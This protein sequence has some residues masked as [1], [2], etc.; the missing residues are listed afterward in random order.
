[1][2]WPSDI[3]IQQLKDL[4]LCTKADLQ[5]CEP[6][7]SS[8]CNDLPDFDSVWLDALTQQRLITPWQASKL[9]SGDGS[10]LRLDDVLLES[11]LGRNTFLGRDTEH[12]VV[13]RRLQITDQSP[14]P[15]RLNLLLDRMTEAAEIS[16]VPAAICLP[17]IV[18]DPG[19]S[20]IFVV[21]EFVSGWSADELLIRGGRFPPRA[22]AEIGR[23]ILQGLAWLES[24][25]QVH[26]EIVLRNLR[27]TRSGTAVLVDPFVRNLQKPTVSLAATTELREVETI[28]P[29]LAGTG[30]SANVRSEMY[31]LGC[32]LW[33]LLT[34][35][36]PFLSTDPIGRLQQAQNHELPDV[37]GIEPECPEWL[38]AEIRLLT[39]RNPD[40][41]PV[42]IAD[43]ADEWSRKLSAST[44]ATRKLVRT[45]P[46]KASAIR[47]I[48][49]SSARSPGHWWPKAAAV[50]LLIPLF[51]AYAWHR[52]LLPTTL[53]LSRTPAVKQEPV[54][55]LETAQAT[56]AELPV[57][58]DKIQTLPLPDAA[59]VV[60]LESGREYIARDLQFAG[61]MHL[62][63][64]GDKL[65][66]VRVPETGWNIK[67]THVAISGVQVEF[68]ERPALP[69]VQSCLNVF[70][71]VLTLNSCIVDSNGGKT[72]GCG[73]AW[74]TSDN[75]TRVVRLQDCV[76]RGAGYGL[77][78]TAAPGRFEVE[79]VLMQQRAGAI[80]MD[81]AESSVGVK[82]SRV[83]QLGG[84][85]FMDIIPESL[86]GDGL[87]V[88]L[89][90]G[91]SVL[92]PSF[93]LLRIAPP[94]GGSLRKLRVEYLLPERGN[95]TI[96]PAD[97]DPVLSFDRSLN[98]FVAIEDSQIVSEALLIARPLFRGQENDA[99]IGSYEQFEL[100]DY[101]GPKLSPRMPG[102]SIQDLPT[103]VS[104]SFR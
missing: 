104:D 63:A 76:F 83:T 55:R 34:G 92:A 6:I 39:R 70:S 101:E 102:V 16:R 47:R 51:S 43:V 19:Q 27:I 28:A 25:Q 59:G 30:R 23:Q 2:R 69:S 50:A 96:V 85:S 7:V 17:D 44:S 100:L 88:Q 9:Q 52:G 4:K 86:A 11:Q 103:P 80:R 14:V 45:M 67:A 97:V 13:A 81:V 93:A 40:L 41:R 29:E 12:P 49:R 91:E 65:A 90:A 1:M 77:W 22:V 37:R 60:L 66:V 84:H 73:V 89:Q 15:G 42:A 78:L 79:N 62:E 87:S 72:N 98:Q 53:T 35:R 3:L 31:S 46:D 48:E 82:L 36:S 5:S 64:D 21:S 99:D 10:L 71:S 95:P 26:G 32:V 94:E 38:A 20:E 75:A 74:S 56:Q 8:L 24:H 18:V 54:E 33:E 61:V 68:L 58:A 57:E